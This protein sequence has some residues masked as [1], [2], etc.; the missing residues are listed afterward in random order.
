MRS[1]FRHRHIAIKHSTPPNLHPRE[2]S[3]RS[4]LMSRSRQSESRQSRSRQSPSSQSRSRQ[5]TIVA[6]LA[7][8]FP[9]NTAART[10]VPVN[11]ALV[12]GS[13]LRDQYQ[14]SQSCH[15]SEVGSCKSLPKSSTW[16][17]PNRHLRQLA[18]TSRPSVCE[19]LSKAVL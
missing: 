19:R 14:S 16:E 1:V 5:C 15:R 10:L 17:T 8:S 13:N 7:A 4:E 11:A 6:R 3:S 9:R 12:G 2:Y 18:I